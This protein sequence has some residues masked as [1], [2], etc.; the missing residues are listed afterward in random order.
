MIKIRMKVK[1]EDSHPY[2]DEVNSKARSDVRVFFAGHIY[3]GTY[4]LPYGVLTPEIKDAIEAG[5][6]PTAEDG[7]PLIPGDWDRRAKK[8]IG[9]GYA[10]EIV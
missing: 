8:L 5:E 6:I 3:D 4:P 7:T 2:I 1:V 9:L 10:E